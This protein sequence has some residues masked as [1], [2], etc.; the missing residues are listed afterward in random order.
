MPRL[1]AKHAR[2]VTGRRVA[3]WFIA[4]FA[5]VIGVNLLMAR[6]AIASFSGTVVDNSYVASQHY[7]EWLAAGR[8]Q[9]A[10]GWRVDAERQGDGRLAVI[11]RGRD[12]RALPNAVVSAIANPAGA[13]ARLDGKAARP[14]RLAHVADGRFVS[15]AP[16]PRGRWDVAIEVV[17]GSER[18]RSIMELR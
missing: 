3:M 17:R 5:V 7:N 8:A 15:S 18:H 16:L 13:S 2:P 9:A 4:F 11:I 14:L 6:F 10:Q 1:P 12:G